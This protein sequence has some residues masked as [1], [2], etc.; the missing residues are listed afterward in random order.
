MG[1]KQYYKTRQVNLTIFCTRIFGAIFFQ[2]KSVARR[3]W[4]F[5]KKIFWTEQYEQHAQPH[6]IFS[7]RSRNT[8]APRN[9]FSFGSAHR[10][11]AWGTIAPDAS[12]HGNMS[13][14]HG[15]GNNFFRVSRCPSGGASLELL[16]VVRGKRRVWSWGTAPGLWHG[17]RR[18]CI[19]LFIT[20]HSL[21][22]PFDWNGIGFDLNLL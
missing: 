20:T 11:R 10:Q 2:R 15:A 8:S 22:R 19:Y 7:W 6:R 9:L 5:S 18:I 17:T 3:R 13:A 12:L 16:H 21:L 14:F 4:F 1:Y